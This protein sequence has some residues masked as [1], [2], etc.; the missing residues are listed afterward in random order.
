MR[1]AEGGREREREREVERERE[2]GSS[3]DDTQTHT[4]THTATL[5][6]PLLA[7]A[8]PGRWPQEAAAAG[9]ALASF[10]LFVWLKRQI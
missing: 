5:S 1:E 8:A 2:R 9:E 10:V 6:R 4:A 7:L 3:A